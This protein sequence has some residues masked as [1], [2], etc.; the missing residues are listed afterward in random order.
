[1]ANLPGAQ[2][3]NV[4]GMT[5]RGLGGAPKEQF[6]ISALNA[7][8]Q[9][10]G[11]L[12]LEGNSTPGMIGGGGKIWSAVNFS[13]KA[14]DNCAL[15]Y[16]LSFCSE[17]AYAVP[18]N[19][20]LYPPATGIPKLAA[21]YDNYSYAMY[22]YF[23][24]SLQQ[25]PCNTTSS[26]QYSLARNCDDC[27][28]SYKQWLCAVTIPRC[29]DWN[30]QASYLAPRA[31]A[32]NFTNGSVPAWIT[33][34]NS[35]QSAQLN[36]VASNSSRNSQII[37]TVI[38]PGPYKEVLPCVD[39]CYDLVQSCPAQ[40]GFYC[41]Q[42]SY[43]NMSYQFRSSDPGVISCSYLGAAYYLSESPRSLW[44]GQQWTTV[45]V[46]MTVVLFLVIL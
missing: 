23:N 2:S 31:M 35:L 39:L 11:F 34:P 44:A 18:S 5:S 8:S 19:P 10:W 25:I 46:A 1:M 20:Q 36:A 17:V 27:A 28:R 3:G 13:T 7:S 32:Q 43:L 14:A 41:P 30:N 38:Q 21:L 9:Y 12:A 6:Y 29:E 40:L 26:A 42:G 33:S 4:A 37:D 15:M 24:Y 45:S 16:N 22:Q